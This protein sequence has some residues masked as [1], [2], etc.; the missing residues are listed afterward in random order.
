MKSPRRSPAIAAL[1]LA[2]LLLTGC[3]KPNPGITAWSG[4]S[5]EHVEALCWQHEEVGG[6]TPSECAE[7]LLARASSGEKNCSN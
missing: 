5:S 4:T 2:P 7:D 3:E 6:L 1:A